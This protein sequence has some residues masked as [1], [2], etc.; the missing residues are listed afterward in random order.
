MFVGP[1]Y[2]GWSVFPFPTWLCE[3]LNCE[4]N[5]GIRIQ[6]R[7]PTKTGPPGR[8]RFRFQSMEDTVGR[9]LQP[10]GPGWS[11]SWKA[12]SSVDPKLLLWNANHRRELGTNW[13]TSQKHQRDYHCHW[14]IRQWANQAYVNGQIKHTSMGKST[15]PWNVVPLDLVCNKKARSSMTL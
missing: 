14:S 2:A 13:R 3:K 9:L 7:R 15:C 4:Q 11:S 8:Q 1:L 12:G 5:N 10:I 6:T